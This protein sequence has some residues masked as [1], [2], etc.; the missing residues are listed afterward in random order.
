MNTAYDIKA[1][2][3]GL[4]G[5]M[6]MVP[7]SSL[8][9]L[10]A[11]ID[12]SLSKIHEPMQLAIIGK[13]SSSKSTLV[14]AILGKEEVMAT[15]QMEV[16]Y[17][18]GW[19]KYGKSD[20]NIIIHHKDGSPNTEKKQSEYIEWTTE[21]N[22]H[23]IDNVSYIE[24]FDDADILKEINIIDTPGL[25]A[26]RG[27][28]SENTLRFIKEV[29]PDALLMLYTKSVSGDVLDIVSQFNE[30]G[31]FS[32]LNAIG[33][34][35]KIDVSWQE[36]C[37]A[38]NFRKRALSIGQ[39]VT[40]SSYKRYSILQKSLFN[41]YPISSLLFLASSVFN[42]KKL[43][44]IK[45]LL[46]IDESVLNSAL[47]SEGKFL[48][49]GNA[50]NLSISDRKQL[51]N[52]IGVYGIY[53]ITQYLKQNPE[54][55]LDDVK[56]LLRKESGAN[57]FMKV[58]HNHFGSRA[59]LIK[60]ESI[61][62]NLQQSIKQSRAQSKDN[63][64]VQLLNNIQ[65]RVTDLFSSLIHEHLEYEMLNKIYNSE[66]DLEENVK[67]EFLCLCGE[68]GFSAKERLNQD[69][70]A[71]PEQLLQ[72][73]KDKENYW[74]RCVALEPDPDEREWM[75]VILSSYSRLRNQIKTMYHQYQQAQA[76]LYNI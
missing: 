62:L 5:I 30:G 53:L 8:P 33:V 15:G 26:L 70:D 45:R 58:L 32:P 65:H 12:N 31:A 35:A 23:E 44:L 13:I 72:I 11:S 76:F 69:K 16:S 14:N 55:S 25:D 68:H 27:K 17:N 38:P 63:A 3:N 18:V 20:S 37:N 59:K 57:E 60:L 39:R 10:Y 49:E 54:A 41:I 24:V 73:C 21:N 48:A 67:N 42:D 66:L 47:Y 34:F 4:R 36:D 2:E 52:S 28:D 9:Q 74:R 29:R 56:Q 6:Q 19:L 50:I 43:S 75:N 40:S 61:F 46:Q 22:K 7:R 1:I 51:T 64:I 71:T